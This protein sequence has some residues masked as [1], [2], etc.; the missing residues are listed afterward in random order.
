MASEAVVLGVHALYVNVIRS[1][2]TREQSERYGLLD[3]FHDGEDR[4]ER[5]L[6]RALDLLADPALEANA[7]AGR[8]KLLAEK[9]DINDY[10]IA[11][12]DRL[13]KVGRKG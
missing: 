3:C 10:Y 5:A 1:G 8:A 13:A 7:R 4:Y 6:A 2:S 12:A 11:E 9:V